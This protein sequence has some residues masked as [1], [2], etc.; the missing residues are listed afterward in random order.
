MAITPML[1]LGTQSWRG[2]AVWCIGSGGEETHGDQAAVEQA[3]PHKVK[4]PAFWE[5][6]APLLWR[7]KR[8]GPY[9][10]GS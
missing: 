5:K 6:D 9:I 10:G 8:E 3:I 1:L 4:R 2:C 7:T